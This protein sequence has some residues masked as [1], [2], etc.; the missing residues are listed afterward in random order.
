MEN[1]SSSSSKPGVDSGHSSVVSSSSPPIQGS[2]RTF[3]HP[4]D[5]PSFPHLPSNA[6]S[7][8]QGLPLE[9]GSALTAQ[10]SSY[11]YIGLR[12]LSD[13]DV[14]VPGGFVHAEYGYGAQS[15]TPPTWKQSDEVPNHHPSALT[16][17]SGVAS[18]SLWRYNQ[19]G[20]AGDFAPFPIEA[21]Q[22]SQSPHLAQPFA[23]TQQRNDSIWQQPQQQLRAM[24]YGNVEGLSG[25]DPTYGASHTTQPASLRYP[26]SSLDFQNATMMPLDPGPHSAPV[27]IQ[28]PSFARPYH[29]IY[30]QDEC[31]TSSIPVSYPGNWYANPSSFGPLQEEP[32]SY[33]TRQQRPG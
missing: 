11:R 23:F 22:V 1:H 5:F 8:Y 14:G 6:P 17:A 15:E 27:G 3:E 25:H 33:E 24:S 2:D 21:R 31:N 10:G 7:A 9:P 18:Q 4:R 20:P 26:R 28:T 32:E 13:R 16:S 12:S 30:P 19:S 29:F